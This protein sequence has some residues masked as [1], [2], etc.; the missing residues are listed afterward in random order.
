MFMSTAFSLV[1]STFL[2]LSL[3]VTMPTILLAV[4]LG[5]S[6]ISNIAGTAILL[7]FLKH[8]KKTF[9]QSFFISTDKTC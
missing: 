2:M 9:N 6:L 8:Q 1:G 4:S 7:Q 3:K 5:T